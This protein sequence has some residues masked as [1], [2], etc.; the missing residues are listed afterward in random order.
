MSIYKTYESQ[1]TYELQLFDYNCGEYVPVEKGNDPQSLMNQ[2]K[3]M[4]RRVISAFRG[5]DW[6]EPYFGKNYAKPLPLKPRAPYGCSGKP[7]RFRPETMI[8]P[9]SVNELAKRAIAHYERRAK[10]GEKNIPVYVWKDTPFAREMH[11]LKGIP[12]V[13][14]VIELDPNEYL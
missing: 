5:K 6:Y 14:N 3:G 9:A 2:A 11:I 1:P 4:A 12:E 10:K 7:R 8:E 13:F